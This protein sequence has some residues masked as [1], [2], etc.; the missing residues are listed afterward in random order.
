MTVSGL[1]DDNYRGITF[2]GGVLNSLFPPLW[3]L[4]IRNAY[5]RRRRQRQG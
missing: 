2:P 5:P 4:G 3:Y 1:V